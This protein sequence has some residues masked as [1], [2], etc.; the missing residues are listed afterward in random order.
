[1]HETKNGDQ[2]SSLKPI[3]ASIVQGS[4]ICSASCVVNASDLLAVTDGNELCKYA[5]D[6]YI[7]PAVIVDLRSTELRSITDWARNNNLKLNLAT[8]Q[9]IIFVNKRRESNFFVPTTIP[10]LKCIQV[11]K[12]LAVIFSNGLSVSLH[13]QSVVTSFAQTSYELHVL[14][15]YGLCESALQEVFRAVVV[16][17]LMYGSS[18]WWG[19]PNATD[20]QKL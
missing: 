8:S 10:E 2:M 14:Q 16:A 6:T 11:L 20:Y 1:M 19:I 13:V 15:D 5:D 4:A 3:S 7:I 12:I 9:E 17:K 18:A